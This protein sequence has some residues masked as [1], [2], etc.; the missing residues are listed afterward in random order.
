MPSDILSYHSNFFFFSKNDIL[1]DEKV[2]V[3]NFSK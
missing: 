1:L 2:R 3:L